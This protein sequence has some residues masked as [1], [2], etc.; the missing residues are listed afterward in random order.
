LLCSKLP[1]KDNVNR[2]AAGKCR[3]KKKKWTS[4]LEK[5]ARELTQDRHMLIHDVAILRN[6]IILLKGEALNHINCECA[7]IREYLNNTVAQLNLAG[8]SLFELVDPRL[9]PES[10]PTSAPATIA[11]DISPISD[12]SSLCSGSNLNYDL[13]SNLV[14]LEDDVTTRLLKL[15]DCSKVL[16]APMG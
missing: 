11:S 1:R 15:L 8:T 7:Q 14:K 5:R 13:N 10:T 16:T 6:E 3:E 12:K 4:K 2:I 9:S